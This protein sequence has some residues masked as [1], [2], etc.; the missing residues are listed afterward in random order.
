MKNIILIFFYKN[1]IHFII[2]RTLKGID[3]LNAYSMIDI[4]VTIIF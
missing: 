3:I 1:I 4:V 2:K